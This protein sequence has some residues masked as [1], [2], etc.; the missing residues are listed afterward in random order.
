VRRPWRRGLARQNRVNAQRVSVGADNQKGVATKNTEN[1]KFG[2]LSP[3]SVY[4]SFVFF[5]A[6]SSSIAYRRF[7]AIYASGRRRPSFLY[8]MRIQLLQVS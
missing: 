3:P 5:V 1:T 6:T 7:A 8:S 4:V 2:N